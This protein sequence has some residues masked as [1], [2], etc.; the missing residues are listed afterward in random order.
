MDIKSNT[1]RRRSNWLLTVFLLFCS[2]TVLIPMYITLTTAV[3]DRQQSANSLWALPTS[4]HWDNFS[5][6][7]AETGF[8]RALCNSLLLTAISVILAVLTNSM[9]AYAIARNMNRKGYKFVY[10]YIVSA[11]FIPFSILMLPLVKEMSLLGLDN[12]YGLIP[13]YVIYNLPFNTMFYVGYLETIPTSLDEAAMLDGANTWQTFWRII[14]PLMGPANATVAIL[15][16]L[17]VWNDFMM[18]LVMISKQNQ[19]TIPLTQYMFQSTFNTD[20]NLSF[21]SYTLAMIPMLIVYLFAQK[22]IIG[23][24]AAGSVKE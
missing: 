4:W 14:F 23:G 20:Y 6:A 7:I 12:L 10:Y 18:P 3:K 19:F 5:R 21:S 16:T 13:L 15:Q 9:V 2:L 22:Q 24:V 11:M 17:W 1:I 8:W